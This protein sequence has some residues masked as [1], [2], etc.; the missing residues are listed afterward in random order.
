MGLHG[1]CDFLSK[2]GQ[3]NNVRNVEGSGGESNFNEIWA[4]RRGKSWEET[5]K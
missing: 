2:F 5:K 4:I 3:T 1:N